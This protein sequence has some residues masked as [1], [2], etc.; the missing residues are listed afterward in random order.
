MRRNALIHPGNL[1]FLILPV[2]SVFRLA[3]ID[4]GLLQTRLLVL[5]AGASVISAWFVSWSAAPPRWTAPLRRWSRQPGLACLLPGVLSIVLRLSLIPWV[6]IPH[7]SVPDEFGHLFLAKTFWLGRLANPPHELWQHFETLHI[8]PQPTFSSMYLAGQAWFLVLGKALTGD[9]FG[10]VLLSTALM[11]SA[12]TWFLRA[13]VPPGWA[14]FGGLFAV[15]RFG[16]ASYW[17]NSY[18]GGSV[19]ALGGALAL[20]AFP[21]LIRSWRPVPAMALTVGLLLVLNTRP[22]EGLALGLVLLVAL[23]VELMRQRNRILWRTVGLSAAISGTVVALLGSAM[24]LHF[25]AVTGSPFTLPYQVNQRI[26]GWPMTLPWFPVRPIEYRHR[27]LAQYK[28]WEVQEHLNVTD[29][30]HVPAGLAVKFSFLWRFYFGVAG[31]AALLFADRIW[32][33]RRSRVVWLSTGAVLFALAL[34]QTGYPHYAAPAAPAFVL[35]FVA[36]LRRLMHCRIHRL[37]F[38]SPLG[39]GIVLLMVIVIAVQAAKL[40][41]GGSPSERNF[42]SWCCVAENPYD[43]QLFIQRLKTEPGDHLVLVRYEQEKY[44]TVEWVYNE[45]D[46]DHARIVFARDMGASKNEELLHYYPNRRVWN[47]L[48]GGG[49]MT[50]AGGLSTGR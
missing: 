17:N 20:G 2:F 10:G 40:E 16:A 44:D 14:L 33:N 28:D 8:I 26:Y 13:Y 3:D 7:P 50:V 25:K 27:E 48:L 1:L 39:G 43:R 31:S 42:I 34:E 37:A 21:R 19:A 4:H 45:P 5:L 9:E 41:P 30:A 47:V 22:W 11:C 32:R 6:P 23:A 49:R 29:L 35:F 38:G 46:I 12:I 15:L 18:W 36:A 24:A